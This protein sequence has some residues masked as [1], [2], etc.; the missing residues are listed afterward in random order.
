MLSLESKIDEAI[1]TG[2]PC[3]IVFRNGLEAT[4]KILRRKENRQTGRKTV[5]L[6]EIH[7]EILGE[8]SIRFSRG[9]ADIQK[10]V[11]K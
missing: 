11:I 3:R 8:A 9:I 4:C 6:M 1:S 10:I 5:T 7:D 2:K